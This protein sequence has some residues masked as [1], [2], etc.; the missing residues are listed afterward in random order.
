MS[1]LKKFLLVNSSLIMVIA[2]IIGFAPPAAAATSFNPNN[3]MDDSIFDNVNSMSEAQI[4]SWL[5]A[6]FPNS[7]ISSNNGFTSP[8]PIGYSPS[9]GYRF[10][11]NVKASKVIYDAA[12]AYDLNP[13]VLLAT[14]QKEQSLVSGGAGCY[15]NTPN[16]SSTFKCDLYSNGGS[17]DCTNACPHSGGCI[18]IAVG[19]GCPYY[20]NAAQEGFSAQIIRAA[21]KLK[22]NKERS[23]G[24]VN[25]NIQKSGWDNSDDPLTCYYGP[26]TQGYRQR[27]K[28]GSND[29]YDGF[30]IIS[31]TSVHI[32][33]GPTAAL[34]YYT[35][36]LSGNQSFDNIFT[37]WFGSLYG[38]TIRDTSYRMF[39][40]R[41]LGHFYTAR[42]NERANAKQ[43]GFNDDGL[44]FKVASSQLPGTVPIYNLYQGSLSDYW[45]LPDGPNF[46][47]GVVLAGYANTGVAFYA[48]PANS[49]PTPENPVCQSGTVPVY[50]MWHGG[51]TEHFYSTN[52]GDHY[53][54]LIYGG[55]VDDG[56]SKYKDGNG[57]VSFCVPQ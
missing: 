30:T 47:W 14:L 12:Q 55:Y 46:Y 36:F 37:A 56:S 27:C 17:Y 2:S 38:N 54:A 44:G 15:P 50:Q 51:H 19:Y 16:P 32:D 8:D 53:W 6:N 10:G 23:E 20:C 13:Q 24:N 42:E 57:G 3:L 11:P 28:G 33:T 43:Q 26:M 40:P 9:A 5:N 7:C 21:W 1:R 48:Y 41:T 52:G 49:N 22:F 25:W 35:P 39:N 18:P 31:G 29:Y 45:L 34:Y 4:D